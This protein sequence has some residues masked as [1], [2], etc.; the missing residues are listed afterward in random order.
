[1]IRLAA[2][3]RR[4]KSYSIH[5]FIDCTNRNKRRQVNLAFPVNSARSD[6]QTE[7]CRFQ[8]LGEFGYTICWRVRLNVRFV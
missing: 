6:L 1:M 4:E 5:D 2:Y 3:A 7:H 8:T